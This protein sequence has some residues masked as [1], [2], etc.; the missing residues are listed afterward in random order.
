MTDAELIA[1]FQ[2]RDETAIAET[3]ARYGKYCTAVAQK[4]L[5]N[6]EDAEECCN[7]TWL[8]VWNSIP[9]QNPVCLRTFL[10]KITRNLALD[11]LRARKAEK[12]S[13]VFSDTIDELAEC[14][15]GSDNVEAQVD[16]KAMEECINTFLRTLS[17]RDRGI[18]LRRY[19]FAE[20]IDD[21]AARFHEKSTNVLLILSRTRKKLHI[22]L[23]EQGY[24]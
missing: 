12:R 20:E 23:T 9:P 21:I 19:F 2:A 6:P 16:A 14:V 11:K 5:N 1:K 10:A 18:F 4:L 22:Y 8:R 17:K 13:F 24:N 15:S 7:D 3:Y